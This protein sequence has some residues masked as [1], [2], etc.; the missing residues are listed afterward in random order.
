MSSLAKL[1]DSSRWRVF[2]KCVQLV[3]GEIML[4]SITII[5]LFNF[6]KNISY[7]RKLWRDIYKFFDFEFKLLSASSSSSCWVRV[8]VVK[9]EFELLST[10]SSCWVRVRVESAVL[11]RNYRGS[12][13]CRV[14]RDCEWLLHDLDRKRCI[15]EAQLLQLLVYYFYFFITLR[16]SRVFCLPMSHYYKEIHNFRLFEFG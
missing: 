13:I 14:L 2:Y 9:Y 7:I 16:L 1:K 8:R 6:E 5:F 15:A 11:K 4:I 10:S 3:Q 12:K